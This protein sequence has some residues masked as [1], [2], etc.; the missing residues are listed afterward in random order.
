MNLSVP[1]MFAAAVGLV[2]VFVLASARAECPDTT[3]PPAPQCPPYYKAKQ[4]F[5]TGWPTQGGEQECT[6]GEDTWLCAVIEERRFAYECEQ[7]QEEKQCVVGVARCWEAWGIYCGTSVG[8]CTTGS[9]LVSLNGPG[10]I[11][12]ACPP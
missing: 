6:S 2:L 10:L 5:C 11:T 3:A 7:T 9:L 8:Q 4:K 12:A 1:R